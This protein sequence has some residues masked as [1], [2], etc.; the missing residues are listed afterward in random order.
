[1]HNLSTRKLNDQKSLFRGAWRPPLIR[2]VSNTQPV[3]QNLDAGLSPHSYFSPSMPPIFRFSFSSQDLRTPPAIW[4]KR[5]TDRHTRHHRIQRRTKIDRHRRTGI[6]HRCNDR[7][8]DPHNSIT[9]DGDAISCGSVRRGKYLRCVGIQSAVVD[10]K[11]EC[12]AAGKGYVLVFGL[13]LCVGEEK[14]HWREQKISSGREIYEGETSC[15]VLGV[16]EGY[17][18]GILEG[19]RQGS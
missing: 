5:K 18:G 1:M 11:K 19:G 9:G 14:C 16:R 17:L 3:T 13:H 7:T 10:V 2:Y 6:R 15:D 4:L 12:D 8:Q